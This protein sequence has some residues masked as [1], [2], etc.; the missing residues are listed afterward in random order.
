MMRIGHGYDVHAYGEGDH[1]TLGGVKIP[2]Q[3]GIIAHSDGDVVYHAAMDALLGAA[4]LGDIGH[5][6]PD[7]DPAFK[8][9]DSRVLMHAVISKLQGLGYGVG[10]I[11]V[12]IVAQS[13]KCAPHLESMKNNLALDLQIP[14]QR[15][16]LKATTTEKLGYIGQEKGVAVH[17]V[18]LIIQEGNL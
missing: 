9:A 10:N 16:N 6:F 12:T 13:P 17:T 1:I 3:K 14:E 15:I 18:V 5:H 2:Y 4:G 11:D 7:T 8:N